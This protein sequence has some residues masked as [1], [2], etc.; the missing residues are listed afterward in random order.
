MG[1]KSMVDVTASTVAP[2]R[3][4]GPMTTSGTTESSRNAVRL[5]GDSR[6]L[7]AWK[8]LSDVTSTRVWSSR[9]V[10]RR[11]AITVST[12]SATDCAERTRCRQVRSM[13][14]ARAGVMAG[15]PASHDGSAVPVA[16]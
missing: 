10:A 6:W 2:A 9:P 16:P 12:E 11:A 5:P 14:A 3:T 7:P 15:M 4:S 8:P 13:R 1:P